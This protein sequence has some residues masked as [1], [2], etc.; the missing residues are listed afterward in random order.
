MT[1]WYYVPEF[2]G[3]AMQCHRLSLELVKLGLTVEVLTGAANPSLLGEDSVDGIKVT[4][5]LRDT[6]T[7]LRHARFGWDMFRYILKNHKKYDLIHSHGFIAPVNL[8]ALLTR[9][10]LVQ[11]ITNLHVDDPVTVKHRKWGRLLM[12]L[13]R[14]ARVIIPTS[15]KLESTCEV[16]HLKKQS[17]TRLPNGINPRQFKPVAWQQRLELRRKLAIPDDHLALL[18]VG[19][20]NYNKGMDMLVRAVAELKKTVKRKFIVL[21]VGPNK[22]CRNYALGNHEVDAFSQNLLKTIGEQSLFKTIRFEGVR[23]NVDEYMQAA[24]IYIHPSRQEGQPNAIIEAMASGLPIVANLLYGITDELVQNGKC[25]YVVNGEDDKEFAAAIRVL[26]NND[27]LR[28]RLATYARVETLQNYNL[29]KIAEKYRS[30]YTHVIN[31]EPVKSM[32]HEL[33]GESLFSILNNIKI[34]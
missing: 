22:L 6:S 7:P 23:A 12:M 8:A 27:S 31:N 4:R 29:W 20:V 1:N 30:L 24:D 15:E 21:V 3:A 34:R 25:G 10:P 33:P 16:K 13:Y 28:L 32:E 2:S 19:S 5:V 18:T 9:T 26:V 11:K 17:F 14:R